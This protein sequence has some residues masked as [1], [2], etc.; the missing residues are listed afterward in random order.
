MRTREHHAVGVSQDWTRRSQGF[1]PLT[2]RNDDLAQPVLRRRPQ[3]VRR[4]AL[5]WWRRAARA[6]AAALSRLHA[7]WLAWL[8]PPE[9]EE[10]KARYFLLGL[11]WLAAVFGS[12]F[13]LTRF[14]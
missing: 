14:L 5:P 10:L 2:H 3:V 4:T 13:A 8:D 9:R 6:V 7:R 1:Q 11:S 12:V